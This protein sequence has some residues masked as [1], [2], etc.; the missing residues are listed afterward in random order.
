[1]FHPTPPLRC[2]LA[3]AALAL[4]T[5]ACS[6]EP[7]APRAAPGR[8]VSAVGEPAFISNAIRYRDAGAHPSTGR[9]GGA[10][11]AARALL[12]KDGTTELEV[13]AGLADGATGTATLEKL[14]VKHMTPNGSLIRTLNDNAVTGGTRETLAYTGL[15]RGG[16][17]KVQA[18]V[19]VPARTGVVTVT[20]TVHLRPDLRARLDAPAQAPAELPVNIFAV[21]SEGNG[22]VGARTDC[23]LYVDG[24]QADRAEGIWVDAGGVVTCAF[25]HTFTAA[26]MHTLRVEAANVDPGDFDPANNAAGGTLEVVAAVNDFIYHARVEDAFDHSVSTTAGTWE[27]GDP[28]VIFWDHTEETTW[29][30]HYQDATITAWIPTAISLPVTR[31]DVSGT[32]GGTRVHEASYTNVSGSEVGWESPECAMRGTGAGSYLV[33][34]CTMGTADEGLTTVTYSRV[35]GDVTYH[36]KGEQQFW[37]TREDGYF[38]TYNYDDHWTS[39]PVPP[40]GPDYTFSVK[41]TDGARTWNA[42]VTLTLK[43]Q[44]LPYTPYP[45]TGEW[46]GVE[47]FPFDQVFRGCRTYR[48]V[49]TLRR[50]DTWDNPG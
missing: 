20:E 22:E 14:Q 45:P 28:P 2:A 17:V 47:Y 37:L 39:A 9:S 12:G 11:L 1:M 32:T 3:A 31:I 26:G 8:S 41:L 13:A 40:F 24:A 18:N 16:L 48:G 43:P 5:G 6:D 25:A 38:Y 10:T 15:E 34:V 4:L 19:R 21:V 35:A 29:D 44:T 46:C 33:A 27:Q 7:I 36:S 49:T 50:A 30:I 42:H 23:V